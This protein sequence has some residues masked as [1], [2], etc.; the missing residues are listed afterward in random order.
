MDNDIIDEY[1]IKKILSTIENV[2][3]NE[4]ILKTIEVVKFV[5]SKININLDGFDE[6]I[7]LSNDK[8]ILME[9]M[10]KYD[11]INI[12][13]YILIDNILFDK[14][15]INELLKRVFL[16]EQYVTVYL[17]SMYGFPK[18]TE[19]NFLTNGVFTFV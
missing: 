12:A 14:Y 6:I 7:R 2:F 11:E 13:Q 8:D 4:E 18:R 5:E 10:N 15:C 1:N 17:R 9:I 19:Y 3:T 16:K